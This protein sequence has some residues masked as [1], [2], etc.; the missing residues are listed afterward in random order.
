M[1]QNTLPFNL[2]GETRGPQTMQA[3]AFDLKQTVTGN[4]AVGL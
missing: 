1:A 2:T 4:R 3:L